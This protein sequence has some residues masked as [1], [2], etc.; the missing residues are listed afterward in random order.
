MIT[1]AVVPAALAVMP[2]TP[3]SSAPTISVTTRGCG[4]R[5]KQPCADSCDDG[6]H[7]FDW[8][9]F[10]VCV[11]MC[12]RVCACSRVMGWL[13]CGFVSGRRVVWRCEENRVI[14]RKK[15]GVN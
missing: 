10:L 6:D 8:K 15:E 12:M 11:Y 7:R 14:V 13:C 5:S 2:A 9:G 3:N 4:D 1:V